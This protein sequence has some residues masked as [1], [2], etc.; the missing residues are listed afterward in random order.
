[1]KT[2][3]GMVAVLFVVSQFTVHS[4]TQSSGTLAGDSTP[5]SP[6][7]SVVQIATDASGLTNVPPEQLPRFGTYWIVQDDWPSLLPLPFGYYNTTNTPVFYSL[8]APG[9]FLEDDT[10][11][12]APQPTWR[13][14]QRGI[15]SAT[16]L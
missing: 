7:D 13:Q 1:M 15:T 10:G 3:R 5:I 2:I 9:Q 11:G 6:P 12:V 4:Q 14:A 8:G 16:L